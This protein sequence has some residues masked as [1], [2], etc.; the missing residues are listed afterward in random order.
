M[1]NAHG[2]N[3]FSFNGRASGLDVSGLSSVIS[4][5]LSE[6]NGTYTVTLAMHP[7]ELGHVQAVMSLTGSELQVSL[8]PHTDHGHAALGVAINDLKN[9]LGR[10]G[11]NVTIDL[12]QPQSQS[13]SS[14]DG[15]R[16]ATPDTRDRPIAPTVNFVPPAVPVR[17]AGQIHLM[18]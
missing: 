4:R 18:L 12:R 3:A 6:G 16:P 1:L 14:S 7:I 17:D 2:P 15:Q 11:V 10:G 5:P 9:E 13:Q 8:T